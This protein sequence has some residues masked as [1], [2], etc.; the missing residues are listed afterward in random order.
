MSI[1]I[2]TTAALAG[3]KLDYRVQSL[4]EA[5]AQIHGPVLVA[6]ESSGTHLYMASPMGLERD[7]KIELRKR[8]LA[9]NVSKYFQMGAHTPKGAGRKRRVPNCAM[10]M[11]YGTPYTVSD[12]LSMPPLAVRGIPNVVGTVKMQDNTNWLIDD[13]RGNKIPI[14]PGDTVPIT[15]LPPE[16]PAVWYLTKYRP[17][18]NLQTLW[19]QFRCSFC[20]REY[21]ESIELK[22]RYRP[23][24]LDFKDT[25]QN[26]IIFFADINTVQR[27]WQA[28]VLEFVDETGMKFYM[29]PYTNKWV[30]CEQRTPGG[31]FVP[32]PSVPQNRFEWDITKYRN[33]RGS[34]RNDI[35]FGLDAAQQWNYAQGRT[36]LHTVVGL[37]EGPL[38]AGRFGPPFT[39]AT[40]KFISP[41]QV[42][43][44]V[45]RFR[46]VIY[47]PDTDAVGLKALADA[48]VAF[49][50]RCDFQ[51]LN[52][53]ERGLG[54]KDAGELTSDVAAELIKPLIHFK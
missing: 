4:A 5:L 14:P 45:T 32:L 51:V 37:T 20:I 46:R 24:P 43:M 9:V 12:L 11:K 52:L 1:N 27:S 42:N 19:D 29:H 26:R 41:E 31:K 40:G 47:V 50:G 13:G 15:E 21:P 2:T 53:Q 49:E 18:Y 25:P 34:T 44:L 36:G 48:R 8:H 17:A 23:L 30:P 22:R 28:R 33:A 38:D 54:N 10:C 39:A 35:L 16:H 3:H 6:N 7:G